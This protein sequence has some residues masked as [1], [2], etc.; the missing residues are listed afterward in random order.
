MAT[1]AEAV[2]TTDDA[3]P[4]PR[5]ERIEVSGYRLFS[6]FSARPQELTVIIGANASGKSSL[7]DL[8]RFVS[9]AASNP[10][11]AEIDPRSAG[12]KLFYTNGPE[13]IQIALAVDHG[14]TKPLL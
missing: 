2:D 3:G 6:E 7:F 9:F 4:S 8:L 5:I 11:P 10:L 1:S 13:R 14:R 12:R